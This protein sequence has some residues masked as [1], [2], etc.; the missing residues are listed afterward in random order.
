MPKGRRSIG[1][2]VSRA[3]GAI[4]LLI[5]LAACSA[6]P[7]T[8]AATW[9]VSEEALPSATTGSPDA[10]VTC[11]GRTFPASGLTAPTGAEKASGPE[12]DALRAALEKFGREFPGSADWTWR[13]AG[14]DDT[15]AIFLAGPGA[16]GDPG[17]A[18]IEV[19][20][21]VGGWEAQ[22][23]G[24]CDPH[25]V[26]SAEFGP[27]SWALDPAFP[28]PAPDSTELHI[29]VW[30]RTCSSGSPT[31]GRMSAP[32]TDFGTETLTITIGV[33]PLAGIQTCPGPP[34]TPALLRLPKPLGQ[35]TLLDGGHV[36]PVPPSPPF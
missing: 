35:R 24:S 14:R 3:L 11:D 5:G 9:P 17:W 29:L 31:T 32:V 8:P 18:S 22:S 33:R 16:A 28:A 13:L 36:P 2:E 25:I 6:E 4:M 10:R 27:A 7:T 34:G 1:R 23:F 19:V 30:E 26:L 15:G 12:F 20:P 21:G